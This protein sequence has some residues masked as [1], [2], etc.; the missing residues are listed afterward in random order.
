MGL[1]GR[2]C[3]IW[4]SLG[5][6]TFLLVDFLLDVEV[7]ADDEEVRDDVERADAH[8]NLGVV[9][10][11]LFGD[12][13]HAEDDHQV[14]AGRRKIWLAMLSIGGKAAMIGEKKSGGLNVHLRIKTH[15]GWYMFALR[16]RK[17]RLCDC[18]RVENC[19]RC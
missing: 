8:E 5:W 3:G 11:D 9:E 6:F 15:H 19:L 12:L 16:V 17:E 1:A 14:G 2:G 4:R 10:G 13:H 18:G 7:H